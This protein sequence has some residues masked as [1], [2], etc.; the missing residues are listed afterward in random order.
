M[1]DDAP[2]RSEVRKC[3]SHLRISLARKEWRGAVGNWAGSGSG[4][5]L[6]FQDHRPYLPGDDPRHIDWAATARGSQAV[7]KLYREEVSP[8]MDIVIDTSASMFLTEEK[9]VQTLRTFLFCL[10]SALSM[11]ASLKIFYQRDNKVEV[12][13]PSVVMHPEWEFPQEKGE[14]LQCDPGL[15][16][17]RSG[18]LRIAVTDLLTP[19][20]P[21]AFLRPLLKDRG[22]A[23][24]LAPFDAKE[25]SPDWSENMQLENCETGQVR[26]QR[27]SKDLLRSYQTAYQTHMEAWRSQARRLG[28]GFA[29]VPAG[30]SLANAFQHEALPVGIVEPWA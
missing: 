29:R 3:V 15:M 8:R 17:L 13:A 7:M 2:L 20:E 22:R 14:G 30:V 16:P 26:R 19:E 9:K 28:I 21:N 25:E 6:E 1:I 5:S 12:V 24:V 23:V 10:E 4:S 18:S 27:I 11:S